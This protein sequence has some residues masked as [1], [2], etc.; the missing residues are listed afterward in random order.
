MPGLQRLAR[1][2]VRGGARPAQGRRRAA[3]AGPRGRGRR[4]APHRG[5]RL[6]GRVRPPERV[7][8]PAAS[9]TARTRR[10]GRRSRR[11]GSRSGCTS[12]GLADMPGASR[13]LGHLMA[14][15]THHALILLIDQQMTL[16]NLVYGGVLER[17]P[18][19]KV[20]GARVRRRVDRALDGP[21]RRVPRELRLGGGPTVAR[22]RASTSSGS[23]GSASI[24][25][26]APRRRSGPLVGGDRFIWASDFPHSDAK[27]PGVVDELREHT[28][29]HGPDGARR[30]CSAATRSTMYGI[31]PVSLTHDAR[32][33]DPRRHRR[34]RHRRAGAHRRRRASRRARSS[35]SAASTR[36][37]RRDDRRRRPARDARL[38]RHPHALRR[39][40]PLGPDRVAGVVARRHHA[41]HRQLRLHARAGRSPTTSSGC[42]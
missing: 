25:A 41:A 3:D 20:V 31:A 29:R 26:S 19:L 15:G 35:R 11:P 37:R 17:H 13:A 38:R 14:P 6:D 22:R 8:R 16:S 1:R 4:G 32:P 7:Q 10:C 27:Y 2:V 28:E 12:A 42:C 39:A 36:R 9:T 33:A 24:P 40:A 30:R 34:R 18:E 5:T 21:A 23:A